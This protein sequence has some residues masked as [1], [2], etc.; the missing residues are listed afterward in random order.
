M[1]K[2]V[3]LA[4]KTQISRVNMNINDTF[5]TKT[6]SIQNWIEIHLL[7]EICCESIKVQFSKIKLTIMLLYLWCKSFSF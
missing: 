2:R 1:S 4:T 3:E 7:H 5:H 6:S